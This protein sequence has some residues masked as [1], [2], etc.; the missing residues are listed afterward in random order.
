[1]CLFANRNSYIHSSWC[2]L[3]PPL[4][5]S[6]FC[7]QHKVSIYDSLKWFPTASD[8]VML[9]SSILRSYPDSLQRSFLH[10]CLLLM[11]CNE[12][13][14]ANNEVQW[15][16][17]FSVCGFPLTYF[18][19]PGF[20]QRSSCTF[21][22]LCI[23]EHSYKWSVIDTSLFSAWLIIGGVYSDA[24]VPGTIL[25]CNL[26]ATDTYIDSVDI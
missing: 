12:W 15:P 18:V 8:F 2:Y 14:K 13:S 22:T 6:S 9:S 1:M 23:M 20:I 17:H 25:S 11:L 16:P 7:W 26:V 24:G 19:S 21:V 3:Y 10:C 5:S 4:C